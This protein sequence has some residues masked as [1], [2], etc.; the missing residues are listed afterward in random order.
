M[1]T[2]GLD[3]ERLNMEG[4]LDPRLHDL[5]SISIG[6]ERLLFHHRVENLRKLVGEIAPNK[7][8]IVTLREVFSCFWK[9]LTTKG[10]PIA[11]D[12]SD[13]HE[14]PVFFDFESRTWR[15]MVTHQ[16]RSI[17]HDKLV[18]FLNLKLPN[19]GFFYTEDY[20]DSEP[21]RLT[22][23]SETEEFL[24]SL[25]GHIWKAKIFDGQ[26]ILDIHYWKE[27]QRFSVRLWDSSRKRCLS[28]E[29]EYGWHEGFSDQS[30]RESVKWNELVQEIWPKE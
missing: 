7:L 19:D 23:S 12:S 18:Y 14:F 4:S 16:P 2:W 11:F 13:F 28:I 6:E 25:F 17:Y 3:S 21:E 10:N 5:F 27:R 29:W 1:G 22:R 9:A 30:K 15:G 26:P 24:R 20:A 8:K